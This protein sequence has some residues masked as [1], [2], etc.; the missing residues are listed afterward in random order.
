[1]GH[2]E[3]AYTDAACQMEEVACLL[4]VNAMNGWLP[5]NALPSVYSIQAKLNGHVNALPSLRQLGHPP[6]FA[7]LALAVRG[8]PDDDIQKRERT[9]E[10][11]AH[12]VWVRL[13][14][15]L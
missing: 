14:H 6:P 13:D 11:L 7:F 3:V 12:V 15:G 5:T 8:P 4:P 2:G 1:M 10:I 9:L